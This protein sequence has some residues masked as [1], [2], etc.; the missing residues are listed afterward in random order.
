[1]PLCYIVIHSS[2]FEVACGSSREDR[3]RLR[4][5]KGT[6]QKQTHRLGGRTFGCWGE[7]LGEGIVR[8]FGID[9]YTLLYL[10]RI[11]N[12][13]LLHSTGNSAQY[14]VTT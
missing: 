11:T 8:E 6:K 3:R 1:M 4:K 5:Q 10:R 2:S 12:K 13:D 9:L 14:Y 7:G